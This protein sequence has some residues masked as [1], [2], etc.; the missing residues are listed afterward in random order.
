MF[1]TIDIVLSQLS[2]ILPKK[3]H[4]FDFILLQNRQATVYRYTQNPRGTLRPPPSTVVPLPVG[5]AV[6]ADQQTSAS[7]QGSQCDRGYVKKD[8]LRGSAGSG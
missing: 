3:I 5:A 1:E 7:H 2:V 4:Y 6:A 8:V